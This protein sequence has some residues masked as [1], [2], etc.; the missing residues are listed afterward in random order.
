MALSYS[1]INTI[2]YKVKVVVNMDVR[3]RGKFLYTIQPYDTL[4]S[5]ARRYNTT[6]YAFQ[7][8]NPGVDLNWLQPGQVINICPGYIHYPPNCYPVHKGISKAELE[9]S[10]HLRMLW[11]QHVAWTRMFII[12]TVSN[13]PDVELVTNRLLRN[14][15]D[16]EMALKPF[17]GDEI[18]SKFNVLLTE[19]LTIAAELVNAAKAG[20]KEAAADAEKRWYA[21]ADEIAFF[22]GSINPYWS[23]EEWKTMLY[24]HLALTKTEAVTR[25][26]GDY[27][28]NIAI[29]DE[30]ENQALGMADVMTKGIV[31]Q[32]PCKFME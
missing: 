17:Y 14:P 16:F 2:I 8:I 7:V 1:N 3:P 28:T 11:E 6:V 31:R 12:N 30:I 24:E 18:A 26:T 21:N 27:K 23:E 22:L 5:L 4:W 20:N 29:C 32:F 10:N 25:L 13:L 9:L 19:H 15:T